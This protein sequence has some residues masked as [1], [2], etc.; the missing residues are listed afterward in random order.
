MTNISYLCSKHPPYDKRIHYKISRIL[1]DKGYKVTNLHP[2][3]NE[4]KDRGITLTGYEQGDGYIGRLRSLKNLYQKGLELSAD[5][6]IVPEP[7]SLLIAYCL[8]LHDKKVKIIFDCHEWYNLHFTHIMKISNKK[9]A[10][11]LN[12]F[13]TVMIKYLSKRI[14]AIITINETM[15]DYYKRYNHNC[16]TIP[17][18]LVS[19][20]LPVMEENKQGYIYFG[21]FW[22]QNQE[23]ILIEA[24]QRLRGS[25]SRAKIIVIGGYPKEQEYQNQRMKERL[26][27]EALQDNLELKGWLPMEKAYSLLST[28]LAGIMRFDYSFFNNY[29]SLPNKLF[30]YM[31]YGMAVI[32]YKYNIEQ[33]KIVLEERCGFAIEEESAEELARAIIYLEANREEAL[34]MGLNA[35]AA[36]K[37]RYN[38]RVYANHLDTLISNF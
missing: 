30:E 17:S 14:D 15:N 20:C 33:S 21:A 19:D 31:A 24:A 35:R 6:I 1:V 22:E 18:L 11:V 2:N 7:D 23:T 38:W 3:G 8:K 16:I 26:E 29:P 25:G 34:E 36:I 28:G 32:C 12:Y 13:V 9:L 10:G 37:N 4:E 5:V 27:Q